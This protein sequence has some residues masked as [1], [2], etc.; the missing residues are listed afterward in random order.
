MINFH[1]LNNFERFAKPFQP[2]ICLHLDENSK[3]NQHTHTNK[4]YGLREFS[5][6]SHWR[7]ILD[8]PM[9][10]GRNLMRNLR[11]TK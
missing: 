3:I 6:S 7:I 5:K 10:S 2:L 1:K 8:T 11:F 9:I 4:K